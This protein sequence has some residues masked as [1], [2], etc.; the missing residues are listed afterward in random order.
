M[1]LLDQPERRARMGEVGKER[2]AGELS[3][4]HSARALLAAYEKAVAR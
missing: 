3:W 1:E 4:A 2:V